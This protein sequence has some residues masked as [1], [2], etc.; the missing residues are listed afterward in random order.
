VLRAVAMFSFVATAKPIGRNTNVYN[1]LAASAF[2]LLLYDPYLIMSVGFQLSYLAVLGIVYF[3]R[4]IYN[5]WEAGSWFMDWAWQLSCVS[6]AAQLSTMA[7]S[8]FY[9][10]QFPVYFLVANLFIIPASFVVLIGGIIL[11][12][13]GVFTNVASWLG[14]FLEWFVRIMN[15][16]IFLVEKLPFSVIDEIYIS[17]LQAWLIALITIAAVAL[18]QFRKFIAVPVLFIGALLFAWDAWKH[19]TG[20]IEKSTFSVYRVQGHSAVEWAEDGT[21]IFFGDSSLTVDRRAIKFHLEPNRLATGIQRIESRTLGK[22][23]FSLTRMRGKNFLWIWSR[24]ANVPSK[25]STDYLIVSN[26]AVSSLEKTMSQIE[27]QELILDSSN[28]YRYCDRLITDAVQRHAR[29]HSV[30]TEGAFIKDL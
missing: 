5:L 23:G 30:L 18:I 27:F 1:T 3:Q 17:A 13:V 12:L 10:H 9:F 20:D 14:V 11:L 6:I 25:I 28:S 24:A 29:I 22:K 8:L 26:N 21:M 16:G 15:E 4:R 7:I 2:C 19:L